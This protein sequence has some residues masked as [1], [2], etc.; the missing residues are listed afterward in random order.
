MWRLMRPADPGGI[1]R[2]HRM[3]TYHRL[4]SGHTPTGDEFDLI[5][6]QVEWSPVI[7]SLF[8][9]GQRRPHPGQRYSVIRQTQLEAAE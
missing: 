3:N 1:L 4:D 2:T 6:C 9:Q 8:R 7:D 5:P